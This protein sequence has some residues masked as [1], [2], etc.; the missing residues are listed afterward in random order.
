MNFQFLLI[1]KKVDLK[2]M[3]FFLKSTSVFF[4]IGP[5]ILDKI[6]ILL[7]Y[8]CI[9]K[10]DLILISNSYAVEQMFLYRGER[11]PHPCPVEF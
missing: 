2:K 6:R 8:P 7:C 10:Q 4:S 9:C 1:L 11:Y 3:F 5:R